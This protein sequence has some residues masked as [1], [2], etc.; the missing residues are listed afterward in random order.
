MGVKTIREV[1]TPPFYTMYELNHQSDNTNRQ[2]H[3]TCG[4][5]AADALGKYLVPCNSFSEAKL[6]FCVLYPGMVRPAPV[7]TG[8][9]IWNKKG[10]ISFDVSM[11]VDHGPKGLHNIP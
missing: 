2:A 5:I 4:G 9:S 3:L 8:C 6:H 7:T 11:N 10:G 1:A